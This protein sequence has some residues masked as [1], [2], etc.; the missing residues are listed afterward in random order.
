MTGGSTAVRNRRYGV[1]AVASTLLAGCASHPPPEPVVVEPERSTEAAPLSAP[2]PERQAPATFEEALYAL[3]DRSYD[4]AHASLIEVLDLCGHSP[5]SQQALLLI[6]SS[7]LDPRNPNPRRSMAAEAAAI[8]LRDAATPSWTRQLGESLYLLALKL[9]ARR[10]GPADLE[11]SELGALYGGIGS[12]PAEATLYDLIDEDPAELA[13]VDKERA[14]SS[15]VVTR[16]TTSHQDRLRVGSASEHCSARWPDLWDRRPTARLPS[17]ASSPYPAR[18]QALR[19]RVEELEAEL[20]R[21][22]RIVTQP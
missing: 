20:E 21:I 8:L 2:Q 17:L 13:R 18:V 4:D 14:K 19:S 12:S 7:E 10:P 3:R 16:P 9:G 1:I 6:A 11:A 15:Y 5:L 22:R